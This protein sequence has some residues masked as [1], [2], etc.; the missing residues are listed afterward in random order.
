MEHFFR[1][2]DKN[3]G[4][5]YSCTETPNPDDFKMH[6]HNL[7]EIY[8]FIEGNGVYKIEGSEYKL[9]NGDILIMRPAE[10]HYIDIDK[11]YPYT[12]MSLHF[13]M[14]IF[15]QID[16]DKKFSEAF[17]QREVGKF[18]LY[19]DSDFSTSAYRYL[20]ENIISKTDNQRLQITSNLAAF[21]NELY[22][23]FHNKNSVVESETLSYEILSYINRHIHENINLDSICKRFYISK[24]H[25]CRVFKQS[26]GSTVAEYISVKRLLKAKSLIRQGENSTKAATLSGFNDYSVFYRNY[27]KHFNSTPSEI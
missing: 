6:M 14:D 11:N 19:R 22:I 24:S 5:N 26:T 1:Y 21:L 16:V 18:N 4:F 17:Y 2:S 9:R 13:D 8:Y 20:L 27:K 10:A 7:C 23:A 12:R 25:L 15:S 3:I